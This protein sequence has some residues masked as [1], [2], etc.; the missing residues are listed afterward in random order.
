[1]TIGVGRRQFISALGGAAVAWPLAARAQQLTPVV[2]FMHSGSAGNY[3]THITSAFI[4]GLKENGFVEDRSVTIEYRYAEGHNDRLPGLVADLIGRHAAVLMAG[5]GPAP[6]RA[7]MDATSSIPIVFLTAS[8]PVAMGLVASI[9]RPG[10][11]V[12]GVSMI[13]SALEAKR[14][15]LLH[16]LAPQ[17]STIAILVNP[18]YPG[19]KLQAQELQEAAAH[20]GVKPVILNAGSGQEIEAA[21]ASVVQQGAGA[22]LVAQDPFLISQSE[23]IV[24]FAANHSLPT[25]YSQRD[26]VDAGGL[27]GYGPNFAEGF[28]QAG[29]YVGKILKGEKPADLPVVQPTKFELVINLKTAKSLGLTVPRTLLVAADEVIE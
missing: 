4:E 15:E 28:R 22:F 9:N 19:A 17:A 24:A 3:M 25:V 23:K 7:A 11:N 21:L 26:F 20:L 18:N 1:M 2:G 29:I 16:E 13:G 8:D 6:A 10:G 12:T 27:A 5:G 14:L